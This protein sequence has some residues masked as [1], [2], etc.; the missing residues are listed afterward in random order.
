MSRLLTNTRRTHE[1]LQHQRMNE[2]PPSLALSVA[3]IDEQMA[4]AM[5][6]RLQ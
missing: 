6:K 2:S 5:R 3:Q 1:R 4:V